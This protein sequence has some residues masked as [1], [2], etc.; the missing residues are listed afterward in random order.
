MQKLRVIQWATGKVGRH[1]LRAIL[2]DPRLEL[3]GVHAHGSDKVGRDAGELCGKPPCGVPA[4]DKVEELLALAADVAVYTPALSK[5]DHLVSLLEAGVNVISTNLLSDL[6]GVQGEVR[7]QLEAACQR[8]GSSLLIT[9]VHPGWA[10]AVAVALSG[11]CRRIEQVSVSESADCSLYQSAETWRALGFSLPEAT[12]AVEAAA[13]A[14][15]LSFADSTR[16]M[17]DA[18]DYRLDDLRFVVEF[19]RAAETVD[20]GWFRMEQGTIAAIRG[21]WDGVVEGQT[22]VKTRIAWYLTDRLDSDW[23]FD[24]EH[25]RIAITG[26][27]GVECRM[28]LLASDYW[29][30]DETLISTALPAVNAISNVVAAPPGILS[31]RQLGLV[32]APAGSWQGQTP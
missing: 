29:G 22:V 14:S 7:K 32:A 18:L 2:D 1:A 8:G 27:P 5:L 6:G 9:G 4:T 19:A 12:P 3:V 13:R 21:G 11:V 26:D 25:Y 10:N 17:A 28:H 31:L 16:A 20:L 24:D 30:A 15:L 23:R